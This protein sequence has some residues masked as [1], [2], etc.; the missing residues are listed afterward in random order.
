MQGPLPL[1]LFAALDYPN[2]DERQLIW[3]QLESWL[4]TLETSFSSE[5]IREI[6]NGVQGTELE[7]FFLDEKNEQVANFLVRLAFSKAVNLNRFRIVSQDSV[8]NSGGLVFL[9]NGKYF[10]SERFAYGKNRLEKS[11]LKFYSPNTKPIIPSRELLELDSNAQVS[12]L[13][14]GFEIL[15]SIDVLQK[16]GWV[17][18]VYHRLSDYISKSSFVGNDGKKLSELGLKVRTEDAGLIISTGSPETLIR[19]SAYIVQESPIVLSGFGEYDLA[20]R[21]PKTGQGTSK[22][23]I[24]A[25][26]GFAKEWMDIDNFGN[27]NIDEQLIEKISS[28]SLP[29]ATWIK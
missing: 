26:D 18:N 17:T 1:I 12:A 3:N 4:A 23:S 11:N 7:P 22:L 8:G 9:S 29:H 13:D 15:I 14:D 24:I 28:W 5:E 6:F 10:Y 16:I 21:L 19:F 25:Q 27:P 2:Q 20:F